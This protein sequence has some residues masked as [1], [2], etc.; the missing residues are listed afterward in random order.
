MA[1]PVAAEGAAGD[2]RAGEEQ[3]LASAGH[4]EG[5][6][7]VDEAHVGE[8]FIGAVGH[9]RG[10][11]DRLEEGEFALQGGGL[12]SEAE[13]GFSLGDVSIGEQ[14]LGLEG[15]GEVARCGIDDSGPLLTEGAE[16]GEV[17]EVGAGEIGGVTGEAAGP[18]VRDGDVHRRQ[19]GVGPVGDVVAGELERTEGVLV[20][21]PGG[22]QLGC[23][24]LRRRARRGLGGRLA[25]VQE[26]GATEGQAEPAGA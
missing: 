18:G 13:I 26:E 1:A 4:P 3:G 9:V 16:A 12:V 11:G 8:D 23:C 21:G 17:D 2:R 10:V 7:G 5:V 14:G 24:G 6:G 15:G 19:F 20:G 22:E 25:G